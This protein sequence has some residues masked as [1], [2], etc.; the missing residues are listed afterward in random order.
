MKHLFL[1]LLFTSLILA[2]SFTSFSQSTKSDETDGVQSIGLVLSGGGAKGIAHIGVIKALEDN[3]IPIDYIAGTSMGAIVGSLYAM[4]YT[5]E[6]M[7][8]LIGS[9]EFSDWSTG[10][11]DKNLTYYFLQDAP[12]PT[13]LNINLNK[14]SESA[15]SILPSSLI[16]PLP[17]N[18]AFM[19]LFAPYTAQCNGDFNKLFVPLRVVASDIT[20]KR[21]R[22]CASG[23]LGDAVR[24]SMSFPLVFYPIDIDGH[25]MYDGGI[26]DNFPVNVMRDDFAPQFMIGVNVASSDSK[27]D[28]MSLIDQLEMMIMQHSDYSMPKQYGVKLRINLDKFGLLDF[29][30]AKTIYQIGYDHAMAM[31]DSIKSRVHARIPTEARSLRRAVFKSQTP[32]LKFDSVNVSGGTKAQNE[33][34]KY[35]FTHAHHDTIEMPQVRRAFYRAIT[36]GK[37]SN[38]LPQ[39]VY[40]DS[41]GLFALDL[42]ADVKDSY[43][44]GIGGFIT[45][46]TNSMLFLTGAYKSLSF[47]SLDVRINGWLGQSYLA[48]EASAQVRL[49]K[50]TPSSLQIQAVASRQKYFPRDRF[51]FQTNEPTIVTSDEFFGRFTYAMAAG[52]RGKATVSAGYGHTDSRYYHQSEFGGQAYMERMQQNLAHAII[53]YEYNNLNTTN[54]PSAGTI[55]KVTASGAIGRHHYFSDFNSPATTNDW[56]NRSWLQAELFIQHYLSLSSTFSLGAEL[57]IL[58]SSRKLLKQYGA[59]ITDAPSYIPSASMNNIFLPQLRA[60]NFGSVSLIPVW[61]LNQMLQLRGKANLFLPHRAILSGSDGTAY[62]GKAFDSPQYFAQLEAMITL[63]FGNITAYTHYSSVV[64]GRWNFGL[65]FG[66]F[67]QAPKFLR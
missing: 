51:F 64:D 37:F 33:Y 18:L 47:N 5:P 54:A 24:A 21:K 56:V 48:A 38:L 19:E 12:L 35:L 7:L 3:E 17:M 11:I 6:E 31:M 13:M 14:G 66:I 29:P 57:N 42:K 65:S 1:R 30:K 44:V 26:Y 40:N 61:K 23:S 2:E 27:S 50:A 58:L 53:G 52:N 10:T 55:C 45:T 22:V 32:C 20:D 15:L 62:Y 63:P 9:P 60:N 67:I 8:Q 59:A 16:N 28:D 25:V 49:L 43:S 4:G 36:P 34:I 41:T 39:A 46:S